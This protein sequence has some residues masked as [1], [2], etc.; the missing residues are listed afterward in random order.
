[1]TIEEEILDAMRNR[2]SAMFLYGIIAAYEQNPDQI[3]SAIESVSIRL[4]SEHTQATW[5]PTKLS[6]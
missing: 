2:P 1:M 4:N 6:S 5:K 3:M